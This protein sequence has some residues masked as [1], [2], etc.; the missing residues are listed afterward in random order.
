MSKPLISIRNSYI[1]FSMLAAGLLLLSLERCSAPNE[2]ESGSP[3]NIGN[4][5]FVGS[6][7]CKSC[8]ASEYSEWLESDHYQAMLP[9]NDSSVLGDFNQVSFAA[10]GVTSSFFKK[11]GKFFINTEGPDGRNQDFEVAYTF[12]FY[13][14]QQYLIAFPDGKLQPTR[15]SWDSKNN[16]WFN[17]YAGDIIDHRDW[18]HWTKNAQNWNTM[19]ASCHS[20]NL[21]KNYDYTTDAYHTDFSEVNVSCESC[22]GP[23]SAHVEFLGSA[24][25]SKGE[26]LENSGFRKVNDTDP[27]VQVN[28][29]APCHARK[30]DLGPLASFGDELLNDL[31]PQ[32]INDEF[33][34]A[35]GQIRDEDYVY[36]SFVQSKM[37]HKDVRCTDCHNPHTG[38]LKLDGNAMCMSCHEPSYNTTQHHFHPVGTAG[39]QCVN[40]HMPVRTYMGN[41]D[42]RDH[43]FRIPRP[44][45]SM[46]FGTPNTCT[47]CHAD[48]SNVW[49]AKAVKEWYG[50]KREYH[51]SD[52]LLP[53]SQL[54]E[55]SEG[56]LIR[57]MADTSQPEIARATAAFYLSSLLTQNSTNAL[58]AALQQEKPLI[59][60][61]AL[62]AL[63]YFPPQ[64]WIE[65]AGIGLT[66]KVKAVRIAAADLY[67][68]LPPEQIPSV[69]Q[70]AFASADAENRKYLQYQT[71]FAVGNVMLADYHLQG[72]DNIQAISS[73]LRALQKDSLMNYARLNL[74]TAYNGV[75]DNRKALQALQEAAAIDPANEQV[76]FNLGLLYYELG[77]QGK[78]MQSFQRAVDLGSQNSNLYYNYGLLLQQQGQLKE[79][80]KI[81]LRGLALDVQAE[82]VNYALAYLYMGQNQ[83]GKARPHVEMLLRI[84]PANPDYEAMYRR[85]N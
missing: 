21:Q 38:K 14:L 35:D 11:D 60:Y 69:F 10:D 32:I 1:V 34:Y 74:S 18:L 82:N 43:S 37:F 42:R 6:A 41:D 15:L 20:T 54:D 2:S 16:R 3:Q 58:L 66:D 39:S 78:A 7:S 75:G 40:C 65:Q 52:D 50:E 56:H 57:L 59:R 73:Y 23:G 33:Y 36:G 83:M 29:C 27:K 81:L 4:S 63:R 64:V 48:Q 61:Q 12:G 26:R 17:Q 44:D 71:D 45:Q 72:G 19:C 85:L 53:G 5:T 28:A 8:H 67:H 77:D 80:E 47:S 62:R 24:S 51:F 22:H 49:A 84:N 76:F 31:I 30:A 9:A 55:R 79:S 46:V 70:S 13:P 25:Y 68:S